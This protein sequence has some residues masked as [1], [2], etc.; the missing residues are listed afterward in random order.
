MT[1][2]PSPCT[3]CGFIPGQHA[4]G[5]APADL[6]DLRRRLSSLDA[7][8]AALT[9]ERQRLQLVSDAVVY[10][11]LSLP[12]EIT[13]AIFLRCCDSEPSPWAALKGPLLLAQIC[14]EWREIAINTPELWRSVRLEA[15]S[16]VALLKLWLARSG[17]APLD[18]MALKLGAE[19][20]PLVASTLHA[21]HW[22]NVK[23]ELPFNSYTD[24]DLGNAALPVLRSIS[25]D[26]FSADPPPTAVVTLNA[27]MLREAHLRMPT[28]VRVDLPWSQ[29]T[30]L[31]LTAI[32]LT[33]C[34][35]VLRK[36]A[37][38]VKL[39]VSTNGPVLPPTKPILL[40]ALESLQCNLM[41]GSI[42]ILDH[43]TLPHLHAL[44]LTHSA[45]LRAHSVMPQDALILM[46]CIRR[47][48]CPLGVF[49]ISCYGLGIDT[50][51]TYLAAVSDSV[52]DVELA[53][54]PAPLLAAL[55]PMNILPHL[56]TLCVRNTQLSQTD[57]W[58]FIDKLQVRLRPSPPRVALA[59]FTLHIHMGHSL[60]SPYM[61]PTASTMAQFQALMADG[62]K[63]KFTM[64]GKQGGVSTQVLL[65]SW[66]E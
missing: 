2:T 41:G 38:L 29:I 14:H 50:F 19:T 25:L 60:V 61:M 8:I 3:N 5:N 31:T 54:V 28:G 64:T 10:P 49:S 30:T 37:A 36:C 55:T 18:V 47:S 6:H 44:I 13:A 52:S 63:V 12:T 33:E 4:P 34:I 9:A 11:I 66:T 35:S 43:L 57:Y 15:R 24:L 65:D 59:E 51:T 48:A 22:Q 56:K 42:P 20:L 21:H 58:H 40:H 46:N 62:L 53:G 39:S 7:T 45:P 32:D 16:S 17:N 1:A 26:V 23:F 27:P